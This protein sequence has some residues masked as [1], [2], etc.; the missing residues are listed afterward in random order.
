MTLRDL[1]WKL[2]VAVWSP[3]AWVYERAEAYLPPELDDAEGRLL[4][5][6]RDEPLWYRTLSALVVDPLA[7]LSD[8]IYPGWDSDRRTLL[9]YWEA[10]RG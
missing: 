9:L 1:R 7:W 8:R 6:L 2:A 5:R 10:R 3:A 4:V